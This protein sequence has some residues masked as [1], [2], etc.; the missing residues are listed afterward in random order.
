MKPNLILFIFLWMSVA[1]IFAQQP[2][3]VNYY[4]NPVI[5]GDFPDPTIIRVGDVYYAAGTS[6]DF[7]PHYLLYESIDLVNWKQIGA[8]FDKTPAWASD[9]FWAPELLYHNDTFYVYYA[10]KRKGDRISCIG[11]A[12]TKNI[13]EGFNDHGILIEWGNEAIDP[14]VFKDDD[15]KLYIFWKAYGLNPDRPIEILG[16]ELSD[17]GLSLIGEHFSVTNYHEGWRGHGDEGQC[18]FKKDGMYYMFYSNGGCCDNRCDYRVMVARSKNLRSGWEQFS[19]PILEGGGQWLCPGHGTLVATPDNRYFYMHHSYHTIDFEYI[20]RQ[21]MIEELIWDEISGW[22]HFKNGTFPSEI[23]EVPFKNTIQ[24]RETVYYSDFSDDK[25]L[26]NWQWD[27]N[28]RKPE[29]NRIPDGIELSSDDEGFIFTGI[30]PKTGNFVF[31]AGVQQN[32]QVQSGICVY[33]NSKNILALTIKGGNLVLFSI[34][35]G[36]EEILAE[37][38]IQLAESLSLRLEAKNGRY[39]RFYYSINNTEW[40]SLVQ[41]TNFGIDGEFLPQWGTAVRTGIIFNSHNKGVARF[42]YVKMLN[43]FR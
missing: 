1:M 3:Q 24:R 20:G 9:S 32:S 37:K 15:D 41:D 38:N 8:V 33:G 28:K 35:N 26:Q 43:R 4:K 10:A 18:I 14:F 25:D 30:S 7:A 6:S 36:Q 19:E 27:L 17:D 42:S 12:T 23:D 31:D 5:P 13:H 22:P 39:Y 16:S 34:K 2:S 29:M 40:I 11:V 21:G